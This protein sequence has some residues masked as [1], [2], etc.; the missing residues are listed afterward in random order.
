[1]NQRSHIWLTLL[2]HVTN[3]GVR[4]GLI[5]LPAPNREPS[6]ERNSVLFDAPLRGVPIRARFTE[7]RFDEARVSLVAWPSVEVDR[8]CVASNPKHEAGEVTASGCLDRSGRSLKFQEPF[9]PSVFISKH[10]RAE[11]LTLPKLTDL[12]DSLNLYPRYLSL[13]SAA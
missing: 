1:M 12:E 9:N 11:L 10:R 5:D 3:E 4:K 6:E 7:W 13:S 8:W 2:A